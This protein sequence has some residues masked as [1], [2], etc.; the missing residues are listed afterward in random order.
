LPARRGAGYVKT[1]AEAIHYAHEHGILHRD[2]KPAN[3]LIDANDQPRVT[4]FGL[5]KRLEG[6]SELTVTGQVL[7]SPNYMP[8]EQATGKRGALS[9]R[10]DVYALGAILYHALT[11]RPP[12]VGEGMAETVQQVLNVEPVSPRVLNPSVPADVETVCLKCLEKEPGKRYAT[13]QM[14]AEEL[15]RFLEGKPVLARPVGRL[16]KAW[17]WCR[18]KP[19]LASLI[20]ALVVVVIGGFAGVLAQLHRAKLAELGARKNAYV[21]DMNLAQQALEE[22][23]L[24]RA[25]ALLE[26]CRP[27]PGQA[28]LRGWEWRW[29]WQRSQT[30]ERATL[31]GASNLVH[32]V[33]LSADGRWLASLSS[34]DALRLWDLASQRCVASSPDV[35]FYRDQILF[36]ADGHR[37]FAGSYETASVKIRDVPSLEAAGELRHASPVNWIA[38]SSDGRVLAAADSSGVKIWDATE[39]RELSAIPAE[40]NL[41]FGR[42]ALSRDGRRVA[43]NDYAGR[44]YVWDWRT[45]QELVELTGHTRVPPWQSAVHDLVFM[46]EGRRLLSTGPDRTVRLWDVD[47]GREMQRLQAHAATVTALALSPDGATLATASCDQTVRLWDATTWQVRATLRGHLD[48]VWG[49]TFSADGNT[50]ATGS[51]D[52]TVKLWD[53]HPPPERQFAWPVPSAARAVVLAADAGERAAGRLPAEGEM[54]VASP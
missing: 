24:G 46:P 28:E 20:V 30:H 32:A 50:L 27:G 40:H 4:D 21:A 36:A 52:E 7:G 47:S 18:R 41:S 48:E 1:I 16:A 10:S 6:D 38:L 22:S 42:V 49:V 31:T 45:H 51:K 17:R 19:A 2:L 35:S 26:Q 12:F 5:A 33:A 23:N 29:L 44:I 9:R 11:G 8:P 37:L 54:G 25:R 13:A 43:F 34:R 15:G 53:A 39:L 3:V 14:L